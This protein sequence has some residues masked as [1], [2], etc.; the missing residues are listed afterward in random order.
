MSIVRWLTQPQSSTDIDPKN[1]LNVQIDAIGV[2]LSNAAG[3]FLA[4]F[5]ARLGASDFQV[6]LLV[7]L[8]AIAGLLLAMPFGQ[9]LQRRGDVVRWFS[10]GRIGSTSVYFVIV[11]AIWLVPRPAL[12]PAIIAI[13][14][15]A[16]IPQTILAV[17]FNVVMDGVAGPQGRMEVMSHRWTILGLATTIGSLGIGQLLDAVSFPTNYQLAFLLPGVGGALGYFFSRQIHLEFAKPE[18]E[19]APAGM[20]RN[21]GT[22]RRLLREQPAFT[23]FTLKRLLFHMGFF[24]AV[25]L[26]PLYFVHVAHAS[27]GW[28]SAIN[29]AQTVILVGAYFFWARQAR[30]RGSRVVLLAATLGLSFYPLM[31][32]LTTQPPLLVTWAAVSGLFQAGL[33]LIFFDELMKTVPPEYSPILVS[34]AQ[35]MQYL[36]SILAPM[37]GSAI[38]NASNLSVALIVAAAI[39]FSGFAVF[40]LHQPGLGWRLP[41]PARKAIR[42]LSIDQETCT[43]AEDAS[44]PEDS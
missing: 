29:I 12:I 31:V 42:P 1:F 20:L 26:Y 27:D 43:P 6:G 15:V 3:A 23:D 9:M 14:A 13:W 19:P 40:L 16:T 18:E 38:S 11:L 41:L 2:G 25:P 10:L 5:L 35:V 34:I 39:R 21:L 22:Y 37:I 32:A 30:S 4:V 44:D 36:A 33:D 17:T 28:I 8:P 24:M 7:S